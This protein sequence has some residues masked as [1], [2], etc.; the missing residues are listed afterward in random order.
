LAVYLAAIAAGGA[1]ALLASCK[2]EPA[3]K[4]AATVEEVA[5]LDLESLRS[6]EEAAWWSWQETRAQL[7]WGEQEEGNSS[8]ARQLFESVIGELP[9]GTGEESPEFVAALEDGL[10]RACQGLGEMEDAKLHLMRALE[11][12]ESL[13]NERELVA[14]SRG[15]LGIL[16]LV[17][18]DYAEARE[19]VEGAMDAVGDEASGTRVFCLGLMGRYQMTVRNYG[20]ARR[21]YDEAINMAREIYGENEATEDLAFDRLVVILR[22]EGHEAALK[23]MENLDFDQEVEGTR[24]AARLNLRAELWRDAGDLPKAEEDL[25]EGI[26]VLQETLG[27]ENEAL[28]VYWANLGAILSAQKKWEKAKECFERVEKISEH[29]GDWHQTR[30]EALWGKIWCLVRVGDEVGA[31]KLLEDGMTRAEELMVRATSNAGEGAKLNFRARIDP[32]SILVE[33]KE[34]EWLGELLVKHKGRLLDGGREREISWRK[35]LNGLDEQE[36][37]VDALRYR[38][39]LGEWSYGAL[40]YS[41]ELTGPH[42]V[43]LGSEKRL[44]RLILLQKALSDLAREKAG[45]AAEPLLRDLYDDFWQPLS[46]LLPKQTRRVTLSPDG[47][48]GLIPWAVLRSKEG[49]FLCEEMESLGLVSNAR[50]VLEESGNLREVERVSFGLSDFSSHRKKEQDEW[51][52]EVA[53]LPG[54]NLELEKGGGQIFRDRDATEAKLAGLSKVPGVLHLATHGVFEGRAGLGGEG[55]D[56]EQEWQRGA[57]LLEPGQGEDGVLRIFEI[58]KLNLAGCELVTVSSCQSG[59]GGMVSGVGVIGVSRAFLKAG[60]KRVLITL[61]EI[62]DSSTPDFMESFYDHAMKRPPEEALWTAQ[63]ERLSEAKN[64]DEAVL[65]YGGFSMTR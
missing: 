2:S 11:M 20:A 16:A 27:N 25:R 47:G 45:M 30:V 64:I 21:A 24:L 31:R 63:R 35:I 50:K 60:A 9:E 56:L 44:E 28:A 65:R 1:L 19:W 57:I 6:A 62:R 59:L 4:P 41:Q 8:E 43:Q 53:D 14:Q 26:A 40:V 33:L 55:L 48:L 36:V 18:G 58:E 10:G 61:W 51:W 49:R 52:G 54:V 37:L 42:W 7:A 22:S 3:E 34:W 39:E 46:L 5:A 38:N 29:S 13:K 23:A 17:Q 15:H 32:F 12:R